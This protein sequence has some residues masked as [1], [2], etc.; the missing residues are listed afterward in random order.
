M[1]DCRATYKASYERGA[2]SSCWGRTQHNGGDSISMG[3]NVYSAGG[4]LYFVH[5]FAGGDFIPVYCLRGGD[6]RRFYN[7]TPALRTGVGHSNG[8]AAPAHGRG[9]C[10]GGC[11]R[12]SLLPQRGSGDVTPGKILKLQMRNP[13]F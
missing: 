3:A 2:N 12:G 6:L 4:K 13:A 5:T 1:S 7:A 8:G 11:G 10:W 9:P